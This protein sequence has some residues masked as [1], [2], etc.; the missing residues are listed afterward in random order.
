[1]YVRF[2]KEDCQKAIKLEDEKFKKEHLIKMV[3]H[4]I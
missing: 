1:M 3:K 2:A 4:K